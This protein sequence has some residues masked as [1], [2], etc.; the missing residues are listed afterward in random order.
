VTP[1]FVP[2]VLRWDYWAGT[3]WER[4]KLLKDET[5]AFTQSGHIRLR[6][7]G[8]G[9]AQKT[10]LIATQTIDRFWIRA[11]LERSQYERPPV[12]HAIRTNTVPVEQAETIRDEVLGGSDGSR[13]QRFRLDNK[14]VV[15]GTLQLEVEQSDTGFEPWTEVE[16]LFGSS[17][18]NNVFTLNRTTGEIRF[19]DG[20][21]GNIPVAYVNNPGANVVARIY[22]VGGG[23]RGNVPAM[24]ISN[25]LVSLDGIDADALGNLQPAHDGRDEETLDEAKVRA[26]H[27]LR[28]RCRAVSVDD[29][30]YLAR[31]AGNVRRAKAL[32]LFDPRFPDTP[33][34]G[35][36]S[37]IVV[38]DGDGPR[39]MPSDGL[40]RTVCAY[41][42]PR[43]LITTEL[44]VLAPRY[45]HVVIR[46]EVIASDEADLAEVSTAVNET[47]RQFF[48]P[49]TGGE[50]GDG[51][52]FGGTVHYSRVY[53]RVFGV[54][55]VARISQLT[56]AVD[57]EEHEACTDASLAPHALLYST[58][59]DVNVR[60][61]EE[62]DA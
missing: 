5:V 56:I 10:K 46:G 13:N 7:P 29:F 48:H 57:G 49:L 40:L 24:A 41:L 50:G 32:P 20:V 39:P 25:L 44:R 43:R 11:V 60:Y 15:A 9:L 62:T 23:R 26:P 58:D 28:S 51:W 22:R 45:Q 19:G 53:Q 37:I 54:P 31:Q 59:H 42:D 8:T 61:D 4:L 2:A 55:G 17:P 14:P 33:I 30:E 16:D 34:P 21:N 35:V 27:T 18:S 6:L 52:P 38:P 1:R 36:I 47:L 12:L 3:R